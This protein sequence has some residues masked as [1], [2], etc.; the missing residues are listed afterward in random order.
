MLVRELKQK[1]DAYDETWDVWLEIAGHE[2]ELTD[3]SED[4]VETTVVLS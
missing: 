1:L 3:I 4:T 2:V